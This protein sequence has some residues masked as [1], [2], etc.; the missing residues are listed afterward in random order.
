MFADAVTQNTRQLGGVR[1]IAAC[2]GL[3]DVVADNGFNAFAPIGAVHEVAAVPG[4]DDIRQAAIF[5]DRRDL[6]LGQFAQHDAILDG[7]HTALLGF[8]YLLRSPLAWPRWARA[9]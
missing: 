8:R 5:G 1:E 9:R 3:R 6:T 4:S 2:T 7:E